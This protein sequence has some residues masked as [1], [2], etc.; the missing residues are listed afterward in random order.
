MIKVLNTVFGE[1]E[2]IAI[3]NGHWGRTELDGVEIAASFSPYSG[4]TMKF[5]D[6]VSAQR[7]IISGV[8]GDQIDNVAR[9]MVAGIRALHPLPE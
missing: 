2:E 7:I 1:M 5:N 3:E 4:T 6:A 8:D 9:I